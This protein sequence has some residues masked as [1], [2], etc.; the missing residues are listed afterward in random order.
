MEPAIEPIRIGLL[1]RH[2]ALPEVDRV[3]ERFAG[4]YRDTLERMRAVA[5]GTELAAPEVAL[6]EEAIAQAASF[7]A[8]AADAVESGL[9]DHSAEAAVPF[10]DPLAEASADA[11]DGA[12]EDPNQAE[13]VGRAGSEVPFWPH[14]GERTA[15]TGK[16]SGTEF[17]GSQGDAIVTIASGEV[18]WSAPNRG[19]GNVIII[20]S[21][22]DYLYLYTG[23]A[24]TLVALGEVVKAGM[25]IAELGIDPHT[26]E[27]KLL[28]SVYKN[29]KRIDP[30]IAPR[31]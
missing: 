28:L 16:L 13:P 24:E 31:G 20:E 10:A 6:A 27:A 11:S 3:L 19:Y 9:L 12:A 7:E 2:Q 26:G 5:A 15:R 4:F 23:L 17:R 14:Y 1:E 25:K 8:L 30:A 18:V 22:N 29:G 21:D